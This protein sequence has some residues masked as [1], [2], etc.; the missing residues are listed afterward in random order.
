MGLETPAVRRCALGPV[1]QSGRP[2]ARGKR[3]NG[4]QQGEK[5]VRL[6]SALAAGG[7]KR[8]SSP[9]P[10]APRGGVGWAAHG[11]CLGRWVRCWWAGWARWACLAVPPPW[12]PGRRSTGCVQMLPP[13]H[14]DTHLGAPK[15]GMFQRT[16]RS[17]SLGKVAS[18][19]PGRQGTVP[20]RG[21]LA[22][23]HTGPVPSQW[24]G[25]NPG[26]EIE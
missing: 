3:A 22:A 26:S 25:G 14:L 20:D 12:S 16:C 7:R 15:V 6:G 2:G 1:S 17:G 9:A 10:C 5:R 11:G 23:L 4:Q 18:T 24:S 19:R 8:R 21:C 13:A